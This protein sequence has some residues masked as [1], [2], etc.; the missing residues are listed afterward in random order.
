MTME[1]NVRFSSHKEIK[2]VGYKSYDNYDALEVPYADAI[3][4]DFDGVMG[5]P[6]TFLGKYSPE[7]FEI[8]GMASGGYD[9]DIVGIPFKGDKDARPIVDG[10]N[11]YARIFIRHKR[12]KK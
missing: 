9:K 12:K 3:P 11:L 5:V 6:I 7:Q 8:I 1:R 10:K 4:S 2:G